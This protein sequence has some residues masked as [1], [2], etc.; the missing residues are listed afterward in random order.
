[1]S[2]KVTLE[3]PVAVVFSIVVLFLLIAGLLALQNIFNGEMKVLYEDIGKNLTNIG[4]SYVS[5]II[6]FVGLI[7]LLIMTHLD[8]SDV[9]ND[10]SFFIV[11]YFAIVVLLIGMA[12][13]GIAVTEQG[14]KELTNNNAKLCITLPN[15]LA[16]IAGFF[17]LYLGLFNKFFNEEKM[18]PFLVYLLFPF[19]VIV[20]GFIFAFCIHFI[21]VGL[22]RDIVR[23]VVAIASFIAGGLLILFHSG[24][25]EEL[26]VGDSSSY[27]YGSHSSYGG[28][29]GYIAPSYEEPKISD[30]E[31]RHAVESNLR[32]KLAN[33]YWGNSTYSITSISVEIFAGVCSINVSVDVDFSDRMA[34]SEYEA[35]SKASE[36]AAGIRNTFGEIATDYLAE[37]PDVGVSS[38][39]VDVSYSVEYKS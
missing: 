28:G 25:G 13:W 1:M 15:S 27:E 19:L 37:R 2:R 5:S 8:R 12:I 24:M 20:F 29:G 18:N 35:D 23:W 10:L 16:N 26:G 11:F 36:I 4:Q 31:Y 6:F 33:Y 22:I 21:P 9:F 39:E 34:M 3:K 17:V 38:V 14:Y 30:T 32:D 7:I